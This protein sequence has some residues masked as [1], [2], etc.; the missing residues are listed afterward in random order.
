MTAFTI[1]P[2]IENSNFHFLTIGSYVSRLDD[3]EIFEPDQFDAI[4]PIFYIYNTTVKINPLF[5]DDAEKLLSILISCSTDTPHE[6]LT[7]EG[8]TYTLPNV[9]PYLNGSLLI[10]RTYPDTNAILEYLRFLEFCNPCGVN[11]PQYILDLDGNVV[12]NVYDVDAESG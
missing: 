5:K 10:K 2:R 8:N 1:T 4:E 9:I 12:I 7:I 3:S 6:K 11:F